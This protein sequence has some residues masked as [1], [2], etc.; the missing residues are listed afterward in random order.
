MERIHVDFLGPLPR[1]TKGNEH[2]LALVDNLTK[3]I[4]AIPT[5]S[6]TAEETARI[7]V[8]EFIARFRVLFDLRS[9]QG[10]YFESRL[11]S[12]T[13]RILEGPWALVVHY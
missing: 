2:V 11:F 12:E 4:E 8:N 1:T 6:Q 3:W 7:A 10:R 9:D 13:C 5:T